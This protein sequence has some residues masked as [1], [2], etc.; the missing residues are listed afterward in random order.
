MLDLYRFKDCWVKGDVTF[1]VTDPETMTFVMTAKSFSTGYNHPTYGLIT[2]VVLG[3]AYNEFDPETNTFYFAYD[4]QCAAGSFGKNYDT[5][6]IL[7][8]AE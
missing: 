2:A 1:R 4:M 5:F 8:Y 6:Q 7:E 3:D